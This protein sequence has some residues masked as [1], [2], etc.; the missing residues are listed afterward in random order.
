MA[1]H[2]PV[3]METCCAN[4]AGL[5][6]TIPQS[7]G[8]YDDASLVQDN[9]SGDILENGQMINAKSL[10][11]RKGNTPTHGNW[12]RRKSERIS[13]LRKGKLFIV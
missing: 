7:T 2:V 6:G 5:D 8:N 3:E 10:D 13:C 9:D 11:K 1:E 12:N 4:L